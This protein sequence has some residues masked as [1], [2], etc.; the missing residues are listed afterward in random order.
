MESSTAPT[1]AWARVWGVGLWRV[2]LAAVPDRP[3]AQDVWGGRDH[4]AVRFA[5]LVLENFRSFGPR[6]IEI[7]LPDEENLLAFVG[8]NNAGKSNLMD[9]IRL[10][11]ASSRRYDPDPA[12]FHRLNTTCEM[13]I[14]LHLREPLRRENIFRKEDEVWGFF[15]RAWQSD[16]APDRGQLKS[17]HYCLDADGTTFRQAR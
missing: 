10:V 7:D 11:L 9:A 17:Q 6:R 1:T 3:L 14:E 15:L 2:G 16:R 4:L 8:A 13:L 12:D 5:K